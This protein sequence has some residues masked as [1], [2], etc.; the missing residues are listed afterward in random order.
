MVIWSVTHVLR[1]SD[2]VPLRFRK[3]VTKELEDCIV[4]CLIVID[5]FHLKNKGGQRRQKS[6]TL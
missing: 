4:N 3:S 2:G 6:M 1:S 5:Q